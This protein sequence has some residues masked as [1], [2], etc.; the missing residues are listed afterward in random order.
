MR[1]TQVVVRVF[2][3]LYLKV[4][5]NDGLSENKDPKRK[6][7]GVVLGLPCFSGNRVQISKYRGGEVGERNCREEELLRGY[8]T[9]DGISIAGF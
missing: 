9:D 3:I 1:E 2:L 4:F 6:G 8:E 7:G 5:R